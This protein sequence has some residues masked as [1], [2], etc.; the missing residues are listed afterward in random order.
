MLK[1]LVK[2]KECNLAFTGAINKK[3]KKIKSIYAV[4]EK[5]YKEKANITIFI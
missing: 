3:S 4:R 5:R 2:D 1:T